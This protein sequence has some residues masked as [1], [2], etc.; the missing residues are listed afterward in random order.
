MRSFSRKP[1][2]CVLL[3]LA[4]AW[5]PST[6]LIALADEGTVDSEESVTE[7]VDRPA[8]G[9]LEQAGWSRAPEADSPIPGRDEPPSEWAR[10][11]PSISARYD[12]EASR[13]G[14][15]FRETEVSARMGTYPVFGPPPPF[16]T[17]SFAH[18]A[19]DVPASLDVPHNLYTLGVELSW[20]R[21]ICE[22]WVL[23]LSVTPTFA[24]DFENTSADAW[25]FRAM[26]L[27]FHDWTPE[28]KVGLGV[29]ATGRQDLPLLPGIGA[30]WTPTPEM[31]VDLF[32]PRPR[33]SYR[34]AANES[35]ETWA[36][37][38]GGLSGGTWAF[39][40]RNGSNDLLTYR[41]WQLLTGVEWTPP[42]SKGPRSTR[43]GL[44]GFAE[45]GYVFGRRL[46][47]DSGEPDYEPD[48]SGLL[49]LG[50]SY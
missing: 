7:A 44:R 33:Y 1:W 43:N 24:S 47:F 25:R 15:G 41:A 2:C 30:I 12:W 42:T 17:A 10:F 31:K 26:A 11:R 13:D 40:R 35:R 6:W 5:V 29:V 16:I 27:A 50:L 9:S 8:D 28:W 22:D 37:I 36:Y 46:E 38:G 4:I 20:M 48:G 14:F 39:E 34:L 32:F 21:P 45:A 49:S 3:A 23:R 18:A 19:F